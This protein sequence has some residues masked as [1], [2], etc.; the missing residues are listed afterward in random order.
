LILWVRMGL[1]LVTIGTRRP[2]MRSSILDD[3]RMVKNC[4]LVE[5]IRKSVQ[6]EST[7]AHALV[8]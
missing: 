7:S 5:V 4:W 2:N 1:M 6:K 8:C 3:Y